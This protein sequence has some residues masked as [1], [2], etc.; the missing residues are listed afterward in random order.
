MPKT[1]L[2]IGN[3]ILEYNTFD[4]TIPA[5]FYKAGIFLS[6]AETTWMLPFQRKNI[7]MNEK[8]SLPDDSM[9]L[10]TQC[11]IYGLIPQVITSN[12]HTKGTV[13]Y[14]YIRNGLLPRRIKAGE[15]IAIMHVLPCLELHYI[16]NDEI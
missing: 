8:V 2:K 6:S 1:I 5:E 7:L 15:Q 16:Q 3:D 10:I 4:K 13:I 11:N 12:K 9:G 14:L